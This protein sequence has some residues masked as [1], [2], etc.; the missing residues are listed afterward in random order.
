ME[1]ESRV[2]RLALPSSPIHPSVVSGTQGETQHGIALQKIGRMAAYVADH[3]TEPLRLEQ[4]AREVR[5][6]PDYAT[7]LFKKVSGLSVMDYVTQHRISHAKRLLL[8]TNDKVLDIALQAGFGSSS[9]FYEA[10][11]EACRQS[12]RE[13]REMGGESH[14]G[15]RRLASAYSS[16][17][18]A[19]VATALA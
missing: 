10:F 6:R 14:L 7:T 13:Y 16:E 8:T 11:A 17:P 1:V 12:P 19:S 3:Y 9:R 2:W 15:R 18:L 5:L 4:V